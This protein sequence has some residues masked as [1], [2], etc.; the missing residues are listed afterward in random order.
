[1]RTFWHK[2][3]PLLAALLL[4]GSTG[5][6]FAQSDGGGDVADTPTLYLDV[7][8]PSP[9]AS[10]HVGAQT[11][12][13]IAF[14]S[15]SDNGP[16]VDHV[17]IFLDDRDGGGM[18]VGRAALGAAAMQPD[19][20]SLM[21]AGWTARVSIPNKLLGPHSLF[22]YALSGVTGDEMRVAIPVQV[23]R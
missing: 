3:V 16:G 13:G 8:N 9:G 18:L 2:T 23:V 1:L 7:A 14:D 6:V 20:P 5:T 12:E 10:I 17:D 11:I 4:A 22:V 15:A 21:G 19:D